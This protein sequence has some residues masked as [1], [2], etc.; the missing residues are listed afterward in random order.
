VGLGHGLDWGTDWIGAWTGLG[1]ELDWGMEWIG[2]WTGLGRGLDWGM[3]W[4]DLDQYTDSWRSFMSAVM[5]LRF[6]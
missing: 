4:I 2:A 1:H 5:N 6:S 3:D